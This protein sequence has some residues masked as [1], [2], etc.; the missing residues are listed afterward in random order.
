MEIAQINTVQLSRSKRIGHLWLAIEAGVFVLLSAVVVWK[1]LI[2]GLRL[3]NTDFPNYYVVARLIREHYCLDRIYEWIWFQRIADHFGIR[4]QLVGFLGL[5]PF[6]AFPIIPLSSLPVLEAKRV[7]IVCNV[8]L[9]AV[10]I[11]LLKRQTRMRRGTVWVI[12]LGA[13]IPLETSFLLGQMHILVMA[14][15]VVAYV[16]HM[17][18]RQ[19]STGCCIAL[20]AALKIYPILF[21]LYFVLKRQWKALGST[22]LFTA[23]CLA[24]SFLVVD[25]EP[26][27]TYIFEQLPRL[28]QGESQNP[29]SPSVTSAS[30]L[31]HRLFLLEPELNPRPPFASARAFAILYPLSQALLVGVVLMRTRTGF[32]NDERETLE[33]SMFLC[34]LMFLSSAPSSYQF[35]ALIAAAVPTMGVL[36]HRRKWKA[37]FVFLCL[38]FSACNIRAIHLESSAASIFTP[39]LDLT[40]WFG[41]AL[42]VFY[43]VVLKRFAPRDETP[44]FYRKRAFVVGA[45]VA[46]LWM[47]GYKRAWSHLTKLET[48]RPRSTYANDGAYLRT[49]PVTADGDL[50]YVAMLRDGYR[51][52]E[53]GIPLAGV[54]PEG[55]TAADQLSFA[56]ARPSGGLWIESASDK[57]S[58]IIH[59]A[60]GKRVRACEI[61]NGESPVPSGDEKQ[62]GFIRE[63]RGRGSLWALSLWDCERSPERLTS[64]A[65]DVRTLAAGLEGSFVISAFHQGRERIYEISQGAEP[66]LVAESDGPLNSPALSADGRLL[67]VREL[68]AH[69]W[70]LASLDLSSRIWKQLTFG[71]C[72]AYTPS[73]RDNQTLIYATDCMRGMGLTTLASLKVDR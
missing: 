12:A 38:Y 11:E 67:V 69:R 66:R 30:A 49:A 19:I 63:E 31:F 43:F 61:G 7:W 44:H 18:G 64:P 37:A 21:C 16:S 42:L 35:V 6:S 62:L 34:L 41:V 50:L 40:L 9:L 73:W 26:M 47:V 70:Q 5:T 1:G 71:D 15:L 53:A 17:R 45:V 59:V 10:A 36:V 46:C 39:A 25:Q 23:L 54:Y 14:L 32:R 27:R 72:N 29:F 68:V 3:L 65:F 52:R 60:S 51:V 24:L 58:Q 57:G 55:D 33:W 2:P 22:A 13:V 48:N 56:I 4:H 20:A 8:A 28:L